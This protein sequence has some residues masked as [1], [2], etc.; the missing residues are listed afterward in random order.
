MDRKTEKI[1]SGRISRIGVTLCEINAKYCF[2]TNDLEYFV[3]EQGLE[4]A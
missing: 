2:W 4:E 1:K 3:L